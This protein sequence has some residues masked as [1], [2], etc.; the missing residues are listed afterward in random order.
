MILIYQRETKQA[1]FL[2]IIEKTQGTLNSGNS[3]LETKTQLFGI[4]EIE[5]IWIRP[6][7]KGVKECKLKNINR[8]QNPSKIFQN[9]G[10]K[11][12]SLVE[13]DN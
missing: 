5:L 2:A 9:L 1:C 4:G 6:L 11:V 12:N 7:L 3:E 8:S 13:V 10:G